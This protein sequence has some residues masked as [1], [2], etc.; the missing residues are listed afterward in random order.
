MISD[1]ANEGYL[2]GG[3]ISV[4]QNSTDADNTGSLLPISSGSKI[5]FISRSNN[6]AV[7]INIAYSVLLVDNSEVSNV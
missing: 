3:E 5:K 2:T 7:D 1:A 4:Y 6:A